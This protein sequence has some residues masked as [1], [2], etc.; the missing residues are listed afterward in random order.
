M[1]KAGKHLGGSD[2]DNWLV[3]YLTKNQGIEKTPLTTRL[4][5]KL[6]IQLSWQQQATE[7]YFDDESLESYELELGRD[8][9][10]EFLTENGFF[11]SLYL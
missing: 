4:A 10:E 9:F 8:R 3:D 2:I 1:A 7:V 6:K 11:A 5:E